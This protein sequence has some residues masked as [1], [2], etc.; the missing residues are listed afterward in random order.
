M[1]LWVLVI[2]LINGSVEQGKFL[3]KENCHKVGK[4]IV[5]NSKQM[6]Y[7]CKLKYFKVKKYD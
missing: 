4:K 6:R 3:D 2:Q 7:T 5:G 1:K